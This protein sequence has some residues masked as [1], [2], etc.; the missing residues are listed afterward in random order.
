MNCDARGMF[1][2]ITH[3]YLKVRQV[4]QSIKCLHVTCVLLERTHISF[5][6]NQFPVCMHRWFCH[7][8]VPLLNAGWVQCLSRMCCWRPSCCCRVPSPQDGV[9]LFDTDDDGYTALHWGVQEG[10]LS[11]VEY[12]VR[13]CGFDVKGRDKVGTY[14]CG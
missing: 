11:M 8:L 6:K 14:L 4:N 12:L 9:H 1:F 2:T 10:Q 3:L 5:R 7:E 13:S